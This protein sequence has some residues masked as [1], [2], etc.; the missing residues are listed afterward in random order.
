MYRI[1]LCFILLVARATLCQPVNDYDMDDYPEDALDKPNLQISLL[2]GKQRNVHSLKRHKKQRRV[3]KKYHEKESS[4]EKDFSSNVSD[5]SDASILETI[6]EEHAAS[7]QKLQ[8]GMRLV[9]NKLMQHDEAI[10]I[11][12]K[13]PGAKELVCKMHYRAP[14]RYRPHPG[15]PGDCPTG[16]P[17]NS[18]IQ[19][20]CAPGK[21]QPQPCQSPP[22]G[23][24][25]QWAGKD[26]K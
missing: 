25:N 9:A 6:L 14:H 7:I 5:E 2:S 21:N 22:C 26:P 24:C 12:K 1:S 19:K 10:A 11:V 4:I 20:L 8:N 18:F 16:T 13:S 3:R 17:P 23:R 15:R